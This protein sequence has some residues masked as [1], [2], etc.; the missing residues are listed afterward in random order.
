MGL[1]GPTSQNRSFF[2]FCLCCVFLLLLEEG[3]EGLGQLGPEK[4][5]KRGMQQNILFL[6]P[7]FSKVLKTVSLHSGPFTLSDH[8]P[9]PN[10]IKTGVLL[11]QIP[12]IPPKCICSEAE[13][14]SISEVDIESKL[15]AQ[16][17]L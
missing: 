15:R 12:N 1:E 16:K 11:F 6:Q 14:E 7:P 9:C 13:I 8:C 17:S 4:R 3:L 2:C 10:A 5:P